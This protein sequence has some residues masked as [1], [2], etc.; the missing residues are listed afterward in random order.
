MEYQPKGLDLSQI[1]SRPIVTELT[2]VIP[3]LGRPIL[4]ESLYWL[5]AG[6]AW[7][8]GVIVVDQ[9]A[10][11]AV[12]T[13]A[14]MLRTIGIEGVY[15]PSSQ[16]GRAAGVNRG[17]ERVKT[18][19]VAVTDDDCFVDIDWLKNMVAQLRQNPAAIV[20]GRV[21]PAG[22]DVIVV[23]TSGQPAVYHR[24]R[25]KFDAMS[26]G[27]MGTSIEVVQ[28]VGLFDEH[29]SLATAEDGEWSYRALRSGIPI[30]YAP[31]VAVRHFGW[32]DE[33]KRAVQYQGY[34]RSHGGFYG[35][36]LRQGDWFIALRVVVH[37]Y[38]ALRRWIR[39]SLTGDQEAVLYGRA[40][41][42]GLLPGIIAGWR[43][44]KPS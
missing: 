4:Q 21:D 36:Y 9:G 26:G 31:E 3:T 28:R 1:E 15:L 43:R 30:I 7:P 34:A 41:F 12:A 33:A 29:V 25:L 6:S 23:V 27:N 17:L 40:Y 44:G 24:P 35:K 37:H 10:N 16:R 39:G 42:T 13:W 11:P 18:R 8:G 38:R 19:F 2:V 14:E 20:T 5:V 22:N 32:R